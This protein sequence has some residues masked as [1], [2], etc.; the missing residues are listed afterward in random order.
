M[1]LAGGILEA[2]VLLGWTLRGLSPSVI[3]ALS[4]PLHGA[5]VWVTASGWA[6]ARRQLPTWRF[7][8]LDVSLFFPMMGIGWVGLLLLRILESRAGPR[9]VG[10]AY[11]EET[12]HVRRTGDRAI[13]PSEGIRSTFSV[14]PLLQIL[15]GTQVPLKL[16][17]VRTLERLSTRQA[18]QLL[19][20]ALGDPHPDVQFHASAALARLDDRFT[21]SMHR[22]EQEIQTSPH[23]WEGY[24]TLG[25]VLLEY[26]YLALPEPHIRQHFLLRA[27][28][29]YEVALQHQSGGPQL[30]VNLARTYLELRDFPRALR[31]LDPLIDQH[32]GD[33][34][35]RFW[36]AEAYFELRN[37]PELLNECRM[38][39]RTPSAHPS[40]RALAR[41]WSE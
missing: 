3:L 40:I 23:R 6:I 29:A 4:L 36:R 2:V 5:S 14:Q 33:S 1:I 24:V 38:L 28:E 8:A 37:Y 10:E 31:T 30:V 35:A 21:A 41:W 15:S 17:A 13:R 12:T 19:K 9:Q 20:K 26:A 32:P 11:W 7:I 27:A 39:L 34:G 22:A 25:N 18:V 16:E